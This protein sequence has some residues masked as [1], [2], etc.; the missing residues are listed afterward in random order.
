MNIEHL[1]LRHL[2]RGSDKIVTTIHVHNTETNSPMKWI[3]CGEIIVQMPESSSRNPGA[4]IKAFLPSGAVDTEHDSGY[5]FTFKALAL[6]FDRIHYGRTYLSGYID[7]PRSSFDEFHI[8]AVDYNP[9][10][11][12]ECDGGKYCRHGKPHKFAKYIPPNNKIAWR[13]LMGQTIEIST[14]AIYNDNEE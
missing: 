1:D 3:T 8:P 4:T 12:E 11:G 6:K 2:T 14:G 5:A 7:I 9:Y 10:T 13:Q